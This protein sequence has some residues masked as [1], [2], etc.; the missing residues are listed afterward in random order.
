MGRRNQGMKAPLGLLSN[1]KRGEGVGGLQ[2]PT[3]LFSR[4]TRKPIEKAPV[5][6]AGLW[7]FMWLELLASAPVDASRLG[8]GGGSIAVQPP[9]FEGHTGS[10]NS[11]P[12]IRS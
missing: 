7:V 5:W 8:P 11:P 1:W 6:G 2:D 4:D 3:E 12:A 10:P 9:T